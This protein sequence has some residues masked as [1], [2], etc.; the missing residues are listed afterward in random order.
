MC[1]SHGRVD[2]MGAGPG[3]G[4]WE[5]PWDVIVVIIELTLVGYSLSIKQYLSASPTNP[6][7]Q[8]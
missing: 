8:V 3:L 7:G 1:V 5:T 4:G 6:V 2:G